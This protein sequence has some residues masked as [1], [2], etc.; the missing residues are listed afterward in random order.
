MAYLQRSKIEYESMNPFNDYQSL[1]NN[2]T[3]M[4]STTPNWTREGFGKINQN[5]PAW[6]VDADHEEAIYREQPDTMTIW[7]PQSGELIIPTLLC[8]FV[9]IFFFYL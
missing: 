7:I 3:I 1:Y 9:S 2:M 6:I 5:L 4:W 8:L